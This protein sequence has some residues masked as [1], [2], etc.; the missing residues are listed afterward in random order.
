MNA[1]AESQEGSGPLLF[2]FGQGPHSCPERLF[3]QVEM[4][5]ALATIPR[6]HSLQLVVD[7]QTT[8]SCA[9]DEKTAWKKTRDQALRTLVDGVEPNVSLQLL[10]ELPIR[11]VTSMQ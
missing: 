9:G 4:T 5:A 1:A 10:K 3:A 6:N 8:S 11:I 7:E 2:P